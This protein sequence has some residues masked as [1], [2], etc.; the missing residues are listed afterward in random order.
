MQLWELLYYIASF[1]RQCKQVN[2]FGGGF[3]GKKKLYLTVTMVPQFVSVSSVRVVQNAIPR[4][5]V[6]CMPHHHLYDNLICSLLHPPCP[7]KEIAG[8]KAAGKV[9]KG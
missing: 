9:L 1:M 4:I 8:R 7:S 2:R 3:S 5:P 6:P